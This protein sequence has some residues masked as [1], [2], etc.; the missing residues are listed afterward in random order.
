MS[1]FIDLSPKDRLLEAAR[2]LFLSAGVPSVGI[3]TVTAKA[4]VARMTLYNNY[5]SKDDLVLA[6][7]KR[8]SKIRRDTILS[9]QE[10]LEGP[11]ER[12]LAMFSVAQE[13]V[14]LKGF[15]GCAFINLAIEVAAS[16]SALHMLAKK[17]KDWIRGNTE[18]QI[19]LGEVPDPGLLAEQICVLWDGGIVGS[20]VHQSERPILI[21]RAAARTLL[22]KNLS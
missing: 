21:A 20:Y 12:T 13:I 10:D 16:D 3:N 18:T 15:R 9:T 7:F 11:I 6:V 2:E 19:R 22:T 1:T 5:A 8:E 4:N 14:S 17:H